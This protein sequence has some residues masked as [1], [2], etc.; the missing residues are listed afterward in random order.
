MDKVKNFFGF[1]ETEVNVNAKQNASKVPHYAQGGYVRRSMP[2]LAVVGDNTS[3]GEII[4]P[5]SKIREQVEIALAETMDKY[6][7]KFVEL[8]SANAGNGGMYGDVYL[9][10]DKVGRV[11]LESQNLTTARGVRK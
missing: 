11:F 6:M 2:Q 3:E 5:E 1:G 8:L 9:D 7:N 4:A 10:K